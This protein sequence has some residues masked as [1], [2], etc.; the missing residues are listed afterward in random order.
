MDSTINTLTADKVR[1]IL[2]LTSSRGFYGAERVIWSLAA[3]ID[4]NRFNLT[5]ATLKDNRFGN[6]ELVEEVAKI[7]GHSLA[8]PCNGRLDK[9]A[10][11]I[12]CDF[13]HDNAIDLLHCHEEK[14]RFYG[15]IAAR[16]CKIPVVATHHNWIRGHWVSN[17]FQYL[18][19][20]LLTR[21]KHITAVSN[22]VSQMMT[23]LKIPRKKI[24]I[25]PNGIDLS[26]FRHAQSKQQDS[27][28]LKKQ[29]NLPINA[30]IVGIFGRLTA[31]KGHY[32]F[33]QAAKQLQTRCPDVHYLIVGDGE[34]REELQ[35]LSRDLG[36]TKQ[37][38]FAGFRDNVIDFYPLLD[39]LVLSSLTEGTPM[40]LLEAMAMNI[41]IIATRVG[42]VKDILTDGHNG[43]LLQ[44]KDSTS[45][46]QALQTLLNNPAEATRLA[47]NAAQTVDHYS[48]KHMA[49]Q[50]EKIYHAVINN[51][52]P[53]LKH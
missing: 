3:S 46:A 26:P 19:A 6:Q 41:P 40:V 25:V 47:T 38:T 30:P 22:D 27:S 7:G 37:I 16:K 13:I 21:C 5:V 15:L 24:S 35:Q 39:I 8:I 52:Q 10:I 18:D 33:L 1:N 43:I 2:I 9:N 28:A 44:A 20:F 51:L 29:L 11:Q 31:A 32:Y 36:L 12:L 53:T 48:S 49:T 4:K 42:G 50:Y 23:K 45:L 34:L 14:S 17:A